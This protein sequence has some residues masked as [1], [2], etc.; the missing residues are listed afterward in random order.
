MAAGRPTK[1]KPEFCEML[2]KHMTRGLSFESFAGQ[3]DT[4]FDSL[5][6]WCKKY[7]E[8]SEAKK[9]GTAKSR[10]VWEMI[11]INGAV[12]KI[13]GF[14]VVAWIFNMKNRFGWRDQPD[15]ELTD[16]DLQFT[17]NYSLKKKNK[18]DDG[19]AAK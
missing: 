4:H 13:K 2:I 3:C 5:Y 16:D 15:I 8:F 14:N 7:P 1:Y 19:T 17:V 12:G 6:E 18:T 10:E 9:I 11:G